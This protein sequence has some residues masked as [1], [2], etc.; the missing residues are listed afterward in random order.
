MPFQYQPY[1]SPFAGSIAQ[2]IA[3][4][5]EIAAH[6]A[7]LAGQANARGAE[8][9][10]A[11]WANGVQN[12]GQ[13]LGSLPLQMQQARRAQSQE[14]ATTLDLAAKRRDAAAADALDK[15]YATALKPDGSIDESA[16][17]SHLPGHLVPS[18]M[19]SI[20]DVKKAALE[21]QE[22]QQK[23]TKNGMDLTA[24]LLNGVK[25]SGYDMQ[26]FM[27]AVRAARD[28]GLI[29]PDEAMRHAVGAVEQGPAYVKQATDQYL[30]KSQEWTKLANDTLTAQ[31]RAASATKPTEASLAVS[32]AGGDQQAA[33]ALGLLKPPTGKYE[34][35]NVTLDGKPNQ[36]VNYD[37]KTGQMFAPGSDQPIDATRIRG[38]TPPSLVIKSEKDV[39]GSENRSEL[40]TMLRTGMVSPSQLSKRGDYNEILAEANRQHKTETGK[41]LNVSKLQLDFEGAKRFVGSLNSNQMTRFR[42]LGV[43]VVN[44]IDEVNQL[45]TQLQQGG[46]ELWNKAKLS[47]VRAVYGNTPQSELANRYAIAVNTLKEEFANLANGGY[48]PTEAAWTLANDQIRGGLGVKDLTSSLGE[49]QRLIN[50]RL[51]APN[52]LAPMGVGG[53]VTNTSTTPPAPSAPIKVGGFTVK[54]KGG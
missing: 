44:T 5:G 15:A 7:E 18:V 38:N 41:P 17:V 1:S 14:E 21:R 54:V 45:A 12:T 25:S 28:S 53:P 13:I 50:Y 20:S 24:G 27:Q 34:Q 48:A 30:S 33:G 32:A 42:Q 26:T 6:A 36:L 43:S 52:E 23:V 10:G 2:L 46:L 8:Q 4:R 9:S 49:V 19:K 11:A 22:L 47:T 35:K 31:S 3:R 51:N 39:Q 29:S 37:P 16:L 40:A